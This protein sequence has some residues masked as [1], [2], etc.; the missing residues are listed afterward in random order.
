MKRNQQAKKIS[1]IMILA[2]LLSVCSAAAVPTGAAAEIKPATGKGYSEKRLETGSAWELFGIGDVCDLYVNAKGKLRIVTDSRKK[3]IYGI[4]GSRAVEKPGAPLAKA[5]KKRKAKSMIEDVTINKKG[6][7]GYF[8]T[9]EKIF[10]YNKKGEIT[11]VFN[12]S[13]KFGVAVWVQRVRWLKKD[14][15]AAELSGLSKKVP[16][17]CLIDMK[18]GK[19][20]KKYK[21]K[22]SALYAADEKNLYVRSGSVRKKT[23][24]IVKIKASSGRRLASIST[25]PIYKLAAGRTEAKTNEDFSA[26]ETEYLRDDPVK[27]CYANGKIY[28]QY[29][30]GIYTWDGKGKDFTTVLDGRTRENYTWFDFI[31][32]D[33]LF[34]K[35]DNYE[36]PECVDFE[37]D[38]DGTMYILIGAWLDLDMALYIYKA[39]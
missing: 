10:R 9:W 34:P 21:K 30:T 12:P 7:I 39:L 33:V 27:L 36:C 4:S 22:Y 38:G 37:V 19:I 3:R 13:K 35:K 16:N 6:T 2:L 15:V 28:L 31:A 11:R 18:K 20:V 8:A 26:A 29:L 23:E 32:D 1:Y 25:A 24:K 5:G 17:V 14:L